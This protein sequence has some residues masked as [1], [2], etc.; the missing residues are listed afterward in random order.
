VKGRFLHGTLRLRL[1]KLT[2]HV[3]GHVTAL[4]TA[5]LRQMQY[6]HA[7]LGGLVAKTG[8]ARSLRK[9]SR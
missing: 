5:R 8:L 4:I 2:R 9:P 3:L 1:A 6:P 7:L